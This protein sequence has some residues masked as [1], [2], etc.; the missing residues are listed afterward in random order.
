M[1]D[2]FTR[3]SEAVTVPDATASTVAAALVTTWISRFGKLSVVTTDRD[4][5]FKSALFAALTNSLG[6]KRIRTTAYHPASNGLV[7]RL[8]RQLK[9]AFRASPHIPWSEVVPL[10]LLGL[11]AAVKPDLGCSVVELVYGTTLR[12]PGELLC[13]PPVDPPSS[14]SDYVSRLRQVMGSL[15]PY[16]SRPPRSASSYQHP[17]LTTCTHVFIHCDAVRKPLQPPYTGPFRVLER[18]DRHFTLD[19]NGRS[20]AVT[21]ERLKPAFF[22]TSWPVSTSH[23]H[24]LARPAQLAV[25]NASPGL[26]TLPTPHRAVPSS[27]APPRRVSLAPTHAVYHSL[28]PAVR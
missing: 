1:I 14:A 3:W 12:L 28:P 25:C 6:T 7:E 23:E 24:S 2:W 21:M 17:D 5:Q 15:R 9:V 10:V 20:D 13:P 27:R 8:H 11:R 4:R 22:D 16:A 26:P 18:A 19:I